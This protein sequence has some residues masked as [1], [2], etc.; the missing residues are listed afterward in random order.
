[1]GWLMRKERG[2]YTGDMRLWL[3]QFSPAMPA[4]SGGNSGREGERRA[5]GRRTAQRL[6]ES[7]RREGQDEALSLRNRAWTA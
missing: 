1:M 3:V 7:K 6:R 2:G 4:T 5:R